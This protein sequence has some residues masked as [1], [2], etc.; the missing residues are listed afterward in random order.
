[1][2]YLIDSNIVFP[3]L[4][5]DSATNALLDQL[6][7]DGFAMSAIT[8]MEVWQGIMPPAS[9]NDR[10]DQSRCCSPTGSTA[11]LS[12][13][14]SVGVISIRITIMMTMTHYRQ[15]ST[16]IIPVVQRYDE[17]PSRHISAIP[18]VQIIDTA[19]RTLLL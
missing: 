8:Q 9:H 14:P 19:C 4:A 12:A 6:A 7:G 18:A 16:P 10:A 1:V 15:Q 2:R 13:Q 11:R 3:H 17:K 5:D